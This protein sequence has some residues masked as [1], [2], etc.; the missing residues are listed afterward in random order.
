ME[1]Q[2]DSVSYVNLIELGFVR[3]IVY[4]IKNLYF[5]HQSFHWSIYNGVKSLQVRS[6]VQQMI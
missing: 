4:V 6:C 5:M 3:E 1:L 2:M